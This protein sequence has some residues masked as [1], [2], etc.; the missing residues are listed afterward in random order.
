LSTYSKRLTI[1]SREIQTAVCHTL[2]GELLKH[3]I[4]EGTKSVTKFFNT[5]VK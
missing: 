2:H 1:S 4:S 3:P 5:S